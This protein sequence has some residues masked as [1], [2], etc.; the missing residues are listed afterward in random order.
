MDK[1]ALLI[2]DVQVGTVPLVPIPQSYL[3]LMVDTINQTRLAGGKIIYVVVSFRPSHPECSPRN[4]IFGGM[5]KSNAYVTGA[6]ETAI[7]PSIA[8]LSTDIV[9]EK[10][11]V[12]AFSGSDLDVV[13]RSLGVEKLVMAGMITSGVVL[14][15][16]CEAADKDFDIVVLRDLCVDVEEETHRVLM[17]NLFAK[18]GE[19]IS[20]RDWIG[21]L[22][23]GKDRSRRSLY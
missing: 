2:I 17:D 14:S 13:L 20:A 21:E 18:R 12:S 11:R 6:P 3:P 19:V 9:V 1:T 8:P 10:K 15:T 7:H 5:A 22:K 16:V 4:V 23:T